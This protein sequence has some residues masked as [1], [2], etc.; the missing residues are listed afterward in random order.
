MQILDDNTFAHTGICPDCTRTVKFSTRSS[1]TEAIWE[2]KLTG[3]MIITDP[4]HM[5]NYED[6]RLVVYTDGSLMDAD[7]EHL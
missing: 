2:F 1:D 3:N 5:G 4:E 6:D 7:T